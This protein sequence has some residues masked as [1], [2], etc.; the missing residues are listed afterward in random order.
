MKKLIVPLA[1][2][3]LS[4]SWVSLWAGDYKSAYKKSDFKRAYALAQPL[5]EKGDAEAQYTLAIL[6]HLGWGITKGYQ[7]AKKWMTKAARQGHKEA[8]STLGWWYCNGY[9]V[10]KNKKEAVKWFTAAANQ[11]SSRSRQTRASFA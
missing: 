6:Y 9:I 3:L 11:A 7:Q 1:L 8:Q 10:E 5:A 4:L 2:L